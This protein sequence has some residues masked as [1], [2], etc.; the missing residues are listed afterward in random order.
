MIKLSEMY[1]INKD[2]IDRLRFFTKK[3]LK[4]IDKNNIETILLSGSVARGDY[5]YDPLMGCIDLTVM[6]KDGVNITP[7]EIFGKDEIPDIP[8]HCVQWNGEYFQIAFHEFIDKEKFVELPESKKSAL[9]ESK[10]LYDPNIKY[11]NELIKIKKTAKNEQKHLLDNTKNYINYILG[12]N[13]KWEKRGAYS[14]MH[15]NINLAVQLGIKCLFYKNNKYAPADDRQLYYTFELD[16][17]PKNYEQLM[18]ELSKQK[19]NSKKDYER[20][21]KI[22]KEEFMAIM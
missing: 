13:K 22:F 19:Y 15:Q 4:T 20:R 3:Y 17:L 1:K 8:F 2:N 6:I 16:K 7:E 14:S 18:N 5:F 9:L 21:I 10:I 12:K 11:K